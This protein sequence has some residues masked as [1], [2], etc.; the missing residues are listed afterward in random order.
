MPGRE[1]C[2]FEPRDRPADNVVQGIVQGPEQQDLPFIESTDEGLLEQR[3]LGS[4][5]ERV[6]RQAAATVSMTKR[7][8]RLKCL[9]GR[10][11]G[12]H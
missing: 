7:Y 9:V 3:L 2:R 12:R 8:W 11:N 4:I 6:A 10:L 1:R 5:P